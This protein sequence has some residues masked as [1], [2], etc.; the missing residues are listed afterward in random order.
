MKLKRSTI[1][2]LYKKGMSEFY[3]ENSQNIVNFK[4]HS[5][6][7]LLKMWLES[8]L[9][10]CIKSYYSLK[11]QHTL[12]NKWFDKNNRNLISFICHWKKTQI[13]FQQS[14]NSSLTQKHFYRST[15]SVTAQHQVDVTLTTVT[16][17]ISPFT[18]ETL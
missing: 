2:Q 4:W 15:R 8:V 11:L 7:H 17:Q 9:W 6:M 18:L 16:F 5:S 14:Y 10:N 13:N 1:N 3:L 12:P